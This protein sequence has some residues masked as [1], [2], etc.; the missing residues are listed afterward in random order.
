MSSQQ[1]PLEFICI[2]LVALV[3]RIDLKVLYNRVYVCRDPCDR[4]PAISGFFSR[5]KSKD[6]VNTSDGS[7][8]SSSVLRT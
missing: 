4:D 5:L 8:L 2:S 7:A 3:L 1:A 6:H